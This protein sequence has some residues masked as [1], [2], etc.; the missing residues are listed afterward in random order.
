MYDFETPVDPAKYLDC[1]F[2]K[3]QGWEVKAGSRNAVE[4]TK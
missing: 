1:R 3:D 4:T 2:L